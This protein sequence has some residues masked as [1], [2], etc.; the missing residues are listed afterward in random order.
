[1][2]KLATLLVCLLIATLH[3]AQDRLPE[4]MDF[5]LKAHLK[6]AHAP[7]SEVDVYIHGPARA[8]SEAVFAHGGRVKMSLP[9]LVSAR[10]PADRMHALA[11]EPAV[12]FFEFSMD[13]GVALNDSMRVKARVNEVHQGLAPLPEGYDGEG[14]ILG[15]IDSG[16][17]WQHPDFLDENGNTRVLKYWD[18]TLPVNGQTPQPYGYGQVWDSTQINA[19]LM[20]SVDQPQWFGHGSTVTG[21][22][23][24]NGL[25]NGRHKGVA[26][27]A[28]MIIVSARFSGNFRASVA[29][30][31]KYI[32]DEAEALGRPVVINASLGTY[33]GSHDGLDASALFIDELIQEQGGR[34]LVAAA[35]NSNSFAPYHLRTE[36]GADTT[37]TWFRRNASSALG[38]PAVFFEVWADL[39]DFQNVR[40]AV[41]ADRANPYRYR[42]ATPFHDISENLGMLIRDTLWS[43]SG[44]RIGI[45]EYF[46]AQRGE[47]VLLQVHM[48]EPD[49]TTYRFRFMTTGSGRFDV[50][51]SAQFGISNMQTN[52]PT[53]ED[54][55]PIVN[56]VLP[57]NDQHIVDSWACSP[58]VLTV[59]NYYNE[60]TY[61]NSLG[62]TVTVPGT[63]GDIATTS[64]KGPART[65]LTKP[66]IAATGDITFS[67]APLDWIAQLVSTN[68]P[69][70]DEG[71]LHLRNGGTSMASPVVAGTA[72]L[73]LQ[74]CPNAAHSEV[75]AALT[76]TANA[77]AFT[78]SVPNNLWGHGKVD[79]FAAVVNSTRAP[80]SGPEG[81]CSGDA[82]VIEGPAGMD[83]YTWSN[84]SDS[85]SV[86]IT[87]EG[88][89]SLVVQSPS[90]CTAW[91]DTV[92]VSE[93][94]LPAMPAIDAVANV[95]TSTPAEGYQWSVN[96]E[97]IPGATAQ[98]WEAEVVGEY[99]V[100]VFD[101][102]GCSA[103]SE[104][105]LVLS[106]GL[107][108]ASA[109]DLE[110]WPS[111]ARDALFVRLHDDLRGQV[112]LRVVDGAGREV[113]ARGASPGQVQVLDLGA[114]SAG[115]YVLR[116][117]TADGP[118]TVRFA[119]ER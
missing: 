54:F 55:P 71:G 6:Q 5:Q 63:E 102:N 65:G 25:A 24:G 112:M 75:I 20:T 14:V 52:L 45:V 48:P 42:G 3:F 19:G 82:A 106:T 41:G 91:S 35:G 58:H 73:Y 12:R 60:V 90:G 29:D 109:G 10:V 43:V 50:W 47:Q 115:L 89:L 34:V 108:A 27:K 16:M 9:Q 81:F 2:K 92:Q 113:L 13:K 119:V 100:T 17:D 26:P 110:V 40:Y 31:V 99:T 4:K 15:F 23:A 79:A 30:A 66:D 62:D 84:G 85:P 22:A 49:S 68:D 37:F 46:A 51:S 18:Q 38:Y 72:A 80:L 87:E 1:M 67:A 44:N 36:V 111:P 98:V 61:V 83:S 32:F 105:L 11:Q 104:P 107:D 69:R 101:A 33:L 114:L 116:V 118:A 57:D 117:E 77:D 95:L 76:G 59:A 94:P 21:T 96:G 56:Y 28:D 53:P 64:S 88:P 103:T 97:P 93:W 74:R 78:G 8:V 86:S 39:D 7:G 70:L